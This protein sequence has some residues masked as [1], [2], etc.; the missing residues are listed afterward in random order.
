MTAKVIF[1]FAALIA[2]RRLDDRF[3][4]KSHMVRRD[5]DVR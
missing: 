4:P 5:R 2:S 3:T 1:S